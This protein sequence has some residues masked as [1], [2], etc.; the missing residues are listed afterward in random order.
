MKWLLAHAVLDKLF[1]MVQRV[2]KVSTASKAQ[3]EA[4]APNDKVEKETKANIDSINPSIEAPIIVKKPTIDVSNSFN[5]LAENVTEREYSRAKIDQS[6]AGEVIEPL[7]EPQFI[8]P[9]ILAKEEESQAKSPPSPLEKPNESFNEL[10]TKDQKVAAESVVDLFLDA[11][12]QLHKF[13]E[14]YVQFSDMELAKMAIEQGIDLDIPVPI[15]ENRSIPLRDFV[16]DFNK[17]SIEPIEFDPEF[18]EKVRPALL[19]VAMKHGWGITDEQFLIYMFGKDITV[20]VGS[21]ISLRKQMKD[22]I[23]LITESAKRS[24]PSEQ[25]VRE[26]QASKESRKRNVE[27]E[28]VEQEE[29]SN[30]ELEAEEEELIKKPIPTMADQFEQSYETNSNFGANNPLSQ[31]KGRKPPAP[32]VRTTEGKVSD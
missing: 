5:P 14:K 10:E 4:I 17:Q 29:F 18:N 24:S 23:Y 22:T 32:R 19:R 28:F 15:D 3:Q 13:G 30:E 21:A 12:E 20:K 6:T 11:Y 9:S 7:N 27:T 25:K 1:K 16:E 31:F 26:E 2:R 8:D